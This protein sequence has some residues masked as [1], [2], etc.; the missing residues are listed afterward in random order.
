VFPYFNGNTI[1]IVEE[2]GSD[3]FLLI[4]IDIIEM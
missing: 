1:Y 4:L 2:T 3:G